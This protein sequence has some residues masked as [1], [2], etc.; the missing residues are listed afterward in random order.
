MCELIAAVWFEYTNAGCGAGFQLES[1]PDRTRYK[2]A[3]AIGTQAAECRLGAVAAES[4]LEG[5][6]DRFGRLRG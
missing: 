6:N 5:A 3:T 4:A 2:V 1:W